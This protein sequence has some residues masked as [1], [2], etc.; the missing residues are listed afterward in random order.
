VNLVER[1]GE[2][3]DELELIH[4]ICVQENGEM[5]V[6]QFKG[7]FGGSKSDDNHRLRRGG[8]GKTLHFSNTLNSCGKEYNSVKFTDHI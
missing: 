8:L 3:F 7:A 4:D 1:E 2:N 6:Y 5:N